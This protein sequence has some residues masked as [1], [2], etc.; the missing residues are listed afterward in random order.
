VGPEG[1]PGPAGSGVSGYEVVTS[2]FF[3]AGVPGVYSY[4]ELVLCPTGKVVLGGG[5]GPLADVFQSL[6]VQ[7]NDS[8]PYAF[9][10]P[11]APYIG[12]QVD[13]SLPDG[14]SFTFG[15]EFSGRVFAICANA[16]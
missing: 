3:E 15:D 5:V 6:P 9:P 16:S 13:L 11:G 12:W 1:P 8:F 2:D 7:V 10:A 4:S 14:R